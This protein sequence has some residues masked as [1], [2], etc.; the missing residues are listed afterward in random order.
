M[1]KHQRFR[2]AIRGETID[3]VPAGFWLHFP[4]PQFFGAAAVEAHL[5]FYREVD[6]DVLKVMNERLYRSDVS[7]AVPADWA[8]WR[9]LRASDPH[10]QDQ[11]D[12]VK[13]VADQIGSEVPIVATI[14]GVFGSAFHGSARSDE[15]L[16][17]NAL[18][19][20]LR[21]SPEAVAPALDA[22]CESLIELSIECLRA[23][24]AG[25]YYAALGGEEHRFDEATFIDHVKPFDLKILKEVER[26][27]DC[28]VLHICKDQVRLPLYADY[29]GHVV[30]W[31]VHESR[32]SLEEGRS[33]FGRAVL[34]GLDDRSG[35]MVDGSDTDIAAE[36]KRIIEAS[37]STS[38][39]LGADCTLPTEINPAKIRAAV[40][41]ARAA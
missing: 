39:I 27:T 28:L 19:Q 25:V 4:E 29:P 17:R 1:N 33:L 36:V 12:I 6:V 30:N 7:I 11:I 37:G 20:H 40:N 2:A 34:G 18:T 13:G 24:A 21:E 8:K 35:V 16:G 15:T 10:F 26:H 14:H 3:Y 9:P 23:G 41:A 31:A 38:F 22:V 5:A 32:Y